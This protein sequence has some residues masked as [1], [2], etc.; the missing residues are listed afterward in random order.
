MKRRLMKAMKAVKDGAPGAMK[1]THAMKAKKAAV[2]MKAMKAKTMKVKAMKAKPMKAR[3][4]AR[5]IARGKCRKA[6][7]LRGHAVATGGGLTKEGL[8]KNKLGKA[9]SKKASAAGRA[10]FERNGIK[11]WLEAVRAAR[12]ALGVQGFVPIGGSSPNGKMFYEKAK[13]IFFE[14]NA[15]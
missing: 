14:R 8:M 12:V 13:Q 3:R 11:A 7:V 10:A 4:K 5:V 1:A 9:V 2:V 15:R 6:V